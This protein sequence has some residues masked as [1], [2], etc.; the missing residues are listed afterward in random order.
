[1]AEDKA[2]QE[3]NNEEV[4]ENVEATTEEVTDAKSESE[5]SQNEQSP[6]EK[7][8]DLNDRFMRLYAEFD[9]FRRRTN[10]EKIDIIANANAGVL[11]DLLPIMDD[12]ERAILNN[13]NVDDI[14]A[15]KEGFNLIF[16]KTK[17]ILESKGLKVMNTKGETFDSELHEAIANIPAPTDTEKGKVVDEMEKGYFLNDK[18]V[19]FAKVIVGQ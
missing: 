19:R 18:V 11:K 7:Y 15:V 10:K 4:V 13:E 17:S 14:D 2:D 16:N 9:N 1:M 5:S 12:F 8:A 3:M 6:E